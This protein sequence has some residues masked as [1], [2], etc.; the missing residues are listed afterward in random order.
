MEC[1]AAGASQL[2]WFDI[3]WM[4]CQSSNKLTLRGCFWLS[5]ILVQDILNTQLPFLHAWGEKDF[6]C[7]QKEV[8]LGLSTRRFFLFTFFKHLTMDFAGREGVRACIWESMRSSINKSWILKIHNDGSWAG[9]VNQDVHIWTALNEK[10]WRIWAPG[11]W[12]SM[13]F[14]QAESFVKDPCLWSL[15]RPRKS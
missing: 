15:R 9:F 14:R 1:V 5:T 12:N 7:G 6:Y 11:W 2:V 10:D 13:P 3:N 4:R 8:N